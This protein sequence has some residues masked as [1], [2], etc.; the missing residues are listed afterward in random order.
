MAEATAPRKIL[1]DILQGS[2]A[3]RPLFIPIVFQLGARIE[4]LPLRAFLTNP[5]KISNALR[6]IRGPLRADGVSCYFDPLLEVEALGG[7]MEWAAESEPPTLCWSGPTERGH[8]PVDLVSPE[9]A[10]KKGRIPVALEVI[11]RL[12]MLLR[13]ES[14]LM[15][16]LAGPFTLAARLTGMLAQPSPARE[17]V[18]EAAL[19]VASAMI[20]QV[21]KAFAEAGASVIF[22]REEMLPP[23]D[24]QSAEDYVSMVSPIFNVNRFYEGLPV[25]QLADGPAIGGSSEVVARLRRECVMC[26]RLELL[27]NLSAEARTQ[28]A[29][30]GLGL[31]ISTNGFER[32]ESL[33]ELIRDVR[34]AL[35]TTV[36]DVPPTT[37]LKRLAAISEVVRTL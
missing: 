4:N 29:G 18:P 12:K 8:L 11:R 2:S 24:E 35:V 30:A 27:Q 16:G 21:S 22:L 20:L 31:S 34:P 5:T 36:D 9:D 15:A 10:L 13:D 19:D 37:D 1:R 23:F 28:I 3:P 32:T 7:R 33:A 17:D 6:Q 25:L 26:A 14:L